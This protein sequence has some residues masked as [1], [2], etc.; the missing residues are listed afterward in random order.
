MQVWS[1]NITYFLTYVESGKELKLALEPDN[2]SYICQKSGYSSSRVKT[3]VIL[4]DTYTGS[5][6]QSKKALQEQVE[7]CQGHL[8]KLKAMA[9]S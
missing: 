5:G 1:D 9:E 3:K 7:A 2:A 6:Q 8:E 4:Y